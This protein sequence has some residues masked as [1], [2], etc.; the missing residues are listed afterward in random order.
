MFL[1]QG[2]R[3]CEEES[4]TRRREKQSS[5]FFPGL[6]PYLNCLLGKVRIVII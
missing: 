4:N 2:I 6:T 1:L 5:E 3:K